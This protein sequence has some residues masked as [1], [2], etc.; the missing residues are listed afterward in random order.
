MRQSIFY[1]L[2][3]E[4][5]KEDNSGLGPKAKTFYAL[6]G[7][8]CNAGYGVSWLKDNM[9]LNTDIVKKPAP[10]MSQSY[11]GDSAVLSSYNSSSTIFDSSS[12]S[13]KTDVVFGKNRKQNIP[14]ECRTY[15]FTFASVPSFSGLYSPYW[16]HD[17]RG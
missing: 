12:V 4:Y 16:K 9:M 14:L 10:S 6:E 8:V 17:S 2:S 1:G 15:H 11:F 5:Y 3:C 13:H 7:A